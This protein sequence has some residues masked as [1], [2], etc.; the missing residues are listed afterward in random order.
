MPPLRRLLIC[1]GLMPVLCGSLLAQEL[2]FAE[3]K[4]RAEAGDAKAQFNLGVMHAVSRGAL[5]DD[6][7]A[8]R[9]FRKAADQG[10]VAAKINLG[11]MYALGRGLPKDFLEAAKLHRYMADQGDAKAQFIVGKMYIEGFT[12]SKNYRTAMEWYLK[13][14]MQG[15]VDAQLSLGHMYYEGDGVHPD[16]V[17]AYAWFH[18]CAY[19]RPSGKENRNKISRILTP[20]AKARAIKRADELSAEIDRLAATK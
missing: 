7:E 20:E 6:V 10:N 3:T 9:W 1:L 15:E 18:L 5:K 17:E 8:V 19:F 13:A 12:V 2:N 14:A 11:D 16:E 4:K